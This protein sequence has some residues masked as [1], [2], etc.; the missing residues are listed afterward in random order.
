MVGPAGLAIRI[1]TGEPHDLVSGLF[2]NPPSC[3]T[4][5]SVAYN[6]FNQGDSYFKITFPSCYRTSKVVSLQVR[7]PEMHII[8][9]DI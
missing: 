6:A 9:G 7:W 4:L 5:G 8:Q 2:W 1:A 3:V